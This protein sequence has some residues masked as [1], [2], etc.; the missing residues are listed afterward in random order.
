MIGRKSLLDMICTEAFEG[1]DAGCVDYDRRPS[2]PKT[3]YGAAQKP[4]LPTC[5]YTLELIRNPDGTLEW[6]E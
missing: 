3:A 2:Q 1:P 6:K 4:D 5:R